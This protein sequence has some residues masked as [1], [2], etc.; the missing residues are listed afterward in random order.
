MDLRS[1]GKSALTPAISLTG[2]LVTVFLFRRGIGFAPISLG[3]ALVAWVAGGIFARYFKDFGERESAQ[4]TS[5]TRWV[6]RWLTQSVV[7]ALFQNVLFFVIPIWFGSA[8]PL[9]VNVVF[10]LLLTALALFACFDDHFARW[11]IAHRWRRTAASAFLFFSVSVPAV[12]LQNL[13][14]IQQAVALCSA[15]A[16]FASV[17]LGFWHKGLSRALPMGLI[18]ALVMAILLYFAGHLLPPVPVQCVHKVA[19][20]NVDKKRPVGIGE[21]FFA[22]TPKVFVHFWVAAPPRFEQKIRF[23]WYRDGKKSGR[24]LPSE[25]VGGRKKGFR[26]RTFRSRP[27]RGNYRVDLETASGQL[28][29]RVRFRVE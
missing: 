7:M 21:V 17:I 11:V 18:S 29:G 20:S 8:E 14:S 22:G 6:M 4:G 19:S 3:I 13:L 28:I 25:I 16:V 27:S 26:T 5:K 12:A 1:M 10:P 23:Q 2:G 9:S 15:V 24:S